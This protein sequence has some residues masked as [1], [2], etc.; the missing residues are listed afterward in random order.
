[1]TSEKYPRTPHL[2]Y[3]P[4]GTSDDRRLRDVGGLL[5]IPLVL[6]EKMDGSNVCLE[7]QAVFARSHG[8]APNHPSFDLLKA[9]HASVKHRIPSEVQVFGEWLYARHSIG[10]SG[11][12]NYFMAFGVRENHMWASWEDV[13]LWA[14]ELGVPTVPVLQHCC[15]EREDDLRA[16]VETHTKTASACG[17]EREGVVVRNSGYFPH[18]LFDKNVAKWVRQGHVQ[19]DEHWKNQQIVRN[20]LAL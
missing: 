11:L 12:P 10:Y 16:A 8:G 20:G 6:T 17:G 13:Q 18:H 19:T 2:P 3:S 5:R 9:Y 7:G 15:F 14:E 4:G 1:M